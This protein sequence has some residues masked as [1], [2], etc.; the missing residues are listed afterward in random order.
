MIFT[1]PGEVIADMLCLLR[2]YVELS[3]RAKGVLLMQGAGFRVA[4]DPEIKEKFDELKYLENS[5]GKT[6]HLAIAPFLHKSSRDL[7]QLHMLG[8]K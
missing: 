8:R 5:I 1:S 3:M 7:W 2:L 6:G 4:E